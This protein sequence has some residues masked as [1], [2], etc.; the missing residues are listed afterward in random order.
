ME[1]L[2]E[3]LNIVYKSKHEM[4]YS[5]VVNQLKTY[6]LK[7]VFIETLDDDEFCVLEWRRIP[8]IDNN[9]MIATPYELLSL[10]Y[11]DK[12]NQRSNRWRRP[13]GGVL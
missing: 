1:K 10:I 6:R 2:P 12:E 3:C 11:N 13:Y 9:D 4:L 5:K 8:S 7:T